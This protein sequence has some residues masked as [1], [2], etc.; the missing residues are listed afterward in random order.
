MVTAGG[1][2]TVQS[3]LVSSTSYF[4]T[5]GVAGRVIAGPLAEA[6]PNLSIL[7]V[8]HGPDNYGMHEVVYPAL[9]PWDIF[10]NSSITLFWQTNKAPQLA[11]RLRMVPSGGTLGVGS[12][13]NWMVYTR[14]QRS[15]FDLCN[16]P[17]WSTD[18]IYPFL[19][20]VC[21]Q[22]FH[23]ANFRECRASYCWL[24]DLHC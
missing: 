14:G 8:E 22:S 20:K 4:D 12:A 19:N 17:G 9:C 15:E 10:P 7:V 13:I 6:D 5:G 1:N 24:C 11:G 18:E 2:Y 3:C 16:A 23:Q 21:H